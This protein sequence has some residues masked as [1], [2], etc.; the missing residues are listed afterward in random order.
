[1]TET[2]YKQIYL[3][4]FYDQVISLLHHQTSIEDIIKFTNTLE[5]LQEISPALIAGWSKFTIKEDRERMLL[6]IEK[7]L[8]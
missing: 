3:D 4:L 5:S 7:D 8:K 1:M 2:N 6:K